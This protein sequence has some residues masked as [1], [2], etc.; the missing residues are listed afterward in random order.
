MRARSLLL[1]SIVALGCSGGTDLENP[2]HVAA[3]ANSA[4]ALAVYIPAY[5]PIGVADGEVTVGDGTCPSVDDDGTTLV[6]TGGCTTEDGRRFEGTATVVRGAEGRIDLTLDGYG[7]ADEADSVPRVT[8]TFAIVRTSAEEQVF[9]AEY[10][11]DGLLTLDVAYTG[12]VEGTYDGATLWNGNG[13]VARGGFTDA[14]GEVAAVTVDQLRDDDVCAGEAASG[15][16]TIDLVDQI[17]VIEYDGATACDEDHSARYRVDGEDRGT[18]PGITCA[19]SPGRSGSGL[20]LLAPLAALLLRI[21][22]PR[23]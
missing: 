9:Q 16:T 17:L 11:Q 4:S 18:V 19:A 10:V 15:T 1:V 20:L 7:R 21:R 6:I 5:E 23:R 14:S 13:S 12:T 2:E 3:W 8:G 22:R